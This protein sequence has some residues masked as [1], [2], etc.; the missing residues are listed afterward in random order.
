MAVEYFLIDAPH[1][2]PVQYQ[3]WEAAKERHFALFQR[4]LS[5]SAREGGHA[6]LEGAAQDAA[7]EAARL[8][9]VAR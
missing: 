2:V 4:V 3:A 8:E 7:D 6:D 1:V 5:L 9:Q